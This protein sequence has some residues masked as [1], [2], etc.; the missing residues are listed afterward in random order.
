ML[1]RVVR[2]MN[3]IKRVY[4]MNMMKEKEVETSDVKAASQSAV[5][6]GEAIREDTRDITLTALSQRHLDSKK[7]RQVVR[8]VIEGASIGSTS[9]GGQAKDALLDAMTGVD[10]ALA[11]SAEASKLAIEEAAGNLKDFGKQDL[12]RAL[13]DLQ[14]LE[15]MFLDTMNEVAKGADELI[16]GALSDMVEHARHSGTA[17]GKT[18]AQTT[19]AL[20]QQLGK[21][22]HEAAS[23]SAHAVMEITGHIAQA[24]AGALD[25]I[26]Q[27]LQQERKGKPPTDKE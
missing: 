20:N 10:E 14:T 8:A 27:T 12:K 26:A 5:E 7:I 21:T 9:K 2:E 6:R 1:D 4:V 13:D 18:A 17:V 3:D 15:D 16:R 25:G 24:A 19:E 22:L 23:A 11:K